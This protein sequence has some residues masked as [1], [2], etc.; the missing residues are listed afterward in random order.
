MSKPYWRPRPEQVRGVKLIAREG[1]VRLFMP[2]GKGK[3]STVY[4]AFKI[5]KDAGLI[6]AMLVIAPCRVIDTSWPQEMVKWADFEGLTYSAIRGEEGGTKLENQIRR[7]QAME[8]DADVYS[9][10]IEGLLSSEWCLGKKTSGYPVNPFAV[11]WLSS[12]RIMLVVDES[13]RFKNWDGLTTRTLRKYLKYFKR[14]VIL[15]GTPKENKLDDLFSQFFITDMG[16]DFGQY[17]TH[18][19]REYLM[20]D[21]D[22]N[23]LPYPD[24]MDRICAK[25]APTTIMLEEEERVPLQ[26]VDYWVQM[27]K[28]AKKL[29][30]ELKKEFLTTIEGKTV[31]APNAGV[32]Y[33]KLRQCAQGAI[34]LTDDKDGR[35]ATLHSAKH[36]QLENL[37]EELN[38]DPL[39]CLYAFRHDYLR[40]EERMGSVPRIGG[41]VSS[42]AGIEAVEQFGAGHLPLLMAHPDSAAY[43]IDGLQHKCNRICWFGMDWSYRKVYQANKRIDR[44]GSTAEEVYIYRI[45]ADCAIER[46]ILDMVKEKK[47]GAEEFTSKLREYLKNE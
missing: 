30:N 19:R 37:L 1:G 15:T 3:T 32:L 27:P 29:Y 46:A 23:I 7:Q 20:R 14:R 17:I 16:A 36:D 33:N 2:P 11:K 18:F 12:K 21:Y 22:G 44:H 38:G 40:L 31:M 34:W 25:I 9:M 39:F 41:G 24:S 4:K 35:Y 43:G 45:L 47:E 6:D 13:Q 42:R 28:E 26:E 10:N 5:L 8:A